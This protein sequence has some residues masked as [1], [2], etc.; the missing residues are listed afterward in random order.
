MALTALSDGLV[1]LK[2]KLKIAVCQQNWPPEPRRQALRTRLAM[3]LPAERKEAV[4]LE[5]ALLAAMQA[6]AAIPALY[7]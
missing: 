5:I 1:D 3:Q 6:S 7:C 4:L 2:R